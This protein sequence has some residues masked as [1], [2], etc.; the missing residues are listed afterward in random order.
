MASRSP[1]VTPSILPNR[2]ASKS[3]V[4]VLKRLMRAMP[5]ARLA[6]VTMPMAAS[7]PMRAFRVVRV[8]SMAERKPQRLAPMK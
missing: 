8:M 5:N 6:V 7:A 4:K 1:S 3:L 2:A